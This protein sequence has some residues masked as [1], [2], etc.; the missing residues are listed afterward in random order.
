M[1]KRRMRRIAISESDYQELVIAAARMGFIPKV[2]TGRRDATKEGV[3]RVISESL[4]LVSDWANT[5]AEGEANE[6]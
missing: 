6:P 1:D 3:E 2:T 5:L 4:A